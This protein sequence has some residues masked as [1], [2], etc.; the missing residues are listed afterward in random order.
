VTVTTT[1]AG[2]AAGTFTARLLAGLPADGRVLDIGGH[3]RVHGLLPEPRAHRRGEPSVIAELEAAGLTGRGGGGYPLAAKIRAVRSASGRTRRPVVVVNG[4][5]SE[6]ASRKDSVL[7]AKAPHLVLDGAQ[8]VAD[9]VG[10]REIIVWLHR[11]HGG[12][13]SGARTAVERAVAERDDRGMV[14]QPVRVVD[15]PARYVAGEASALARHLSGG[16]ARPQTTPPRVSE[17]GVGGRPTLVSNAETLAHA[18]LIAR[19]GADWFH[20]VGTPEEPGT[21]LITVF[22]AVRSPGVLEAAAGTTLGALVHAV[23]ALTAPPAAV[24][25]GGY[26]GGWLRPTEA[27][28]VPYS[29]A[30]LRSVGLAPG[31]GLVGVLPADRCVV[32]ET[33]RLVGWLAGESAGQCGPCLNG[34]PALA[35]GLR[36]L[37]GEVGRAV[38]ATE[39][40]ARLAR[41]A[42]MVDGRGA[43]HHPDGVAA[44][45]RSLLTHFADDVAAHADGRPCDAARTVP[46]LG[47]L[48]LP[49]PDSVARLDG[50]LWR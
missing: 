33:A 49:A 23:G 34:L 20:Q 29:R 39:L 37:A 27:W 45:V 26:A 2:P 15:G 50:A 19:H 16:E 5:E 28:P 22:G 17:R 21:L 4:A 12:G 46:Y 48:P 13:P 14:R 32:V 3:L 11:G 35:A 40:P 42:G 18:A 9:A 38:R 41:W 6:P 44:L 24:L 47:Y 7:L 30:G 1:S 8:V 31:V 36:Q 25:V 43:C 10:G